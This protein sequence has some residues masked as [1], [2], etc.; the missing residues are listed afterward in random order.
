MALGTGGGGQ[1]RPLIFRVTGNADDF[2]AV[3][4]AGGMFRVFDVVTNITFERSYST[5][6]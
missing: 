6:R 5:S 1:S 2:H 3:Q 4:R